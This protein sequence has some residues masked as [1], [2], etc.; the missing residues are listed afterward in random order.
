MDP[1]GAENL[2]KFQIPYY[3]LDEFDIHIGYLIG[4]GSLLQ[5]ENRIKVV[6][7][8]HNG[9]FNYLSIFNIRR[10]IKKNHIQII[11]NQYQ[12]IQLQLSKTWK[13]LT[14][15]DRFYQLIQF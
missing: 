14:L 3:N 11:Q 6:D 9:K 8:S 15:F 4:G 2:L 12:L 7:F 10:Y 5:N 1:G 13:L